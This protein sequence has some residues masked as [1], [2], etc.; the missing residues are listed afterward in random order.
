M[1]NLFKGQYSPFSVLQPFAA[2]LITA[3]LIISGFSLDALKILITI[4][5]GPI[6]LIYNFFNF[7][8]SFSLEFSNRRGKIWRL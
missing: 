7:I 8:I 4:Y 6:V 5:I 1:F 2:D 3:D